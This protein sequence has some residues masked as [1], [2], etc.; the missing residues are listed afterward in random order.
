MTVAELIAKLQTMPQ[1]LQVSV[2]DH[3][4]GHFV[5]SVDD[6]FHCSDINSVIIVVN[7]NN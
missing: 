6:V 5:E 4:S 3:Q 2:D 1:H 7:E